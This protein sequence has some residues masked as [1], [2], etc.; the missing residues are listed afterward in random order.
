MS[1]PSHFRARDGRPFRFAGGMRSRVG[2]KE[3]SSRDRVFA[4]ETEVIQY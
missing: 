1:A 3:M 4:A 2:V